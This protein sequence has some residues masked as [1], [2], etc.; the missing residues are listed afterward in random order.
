MQ[1][2]PKLVNEDTAAATAPAELDFERLKAFHQEEKDNLESEVQA[3]RARAREAVARARVGIPLTAADWT[4]WFV[5]NRESF[6]A[7]QRTAPTSRRALCKRWG[8]AADAP[9][10]VPRFAPA[11]DEGV[12][13][14]RNQARWC[15]LLQGRTG[16]YG[17]QMLA[18]SRIKILLVC[19]FR[20]KSYA[21]DM[22]PWQRT[23]GRF[24]ITDCAAVLQ[25]RVRPLGNA[26]EEAD[27]VS[28]VFE[29]CI[30]GA[31]LANDVEL[32]VLSLAQ[33]TDPLPPPKR[34]R[35]S[36]AAAPDGDGASSQEEALAGDASDC[37]SSISEC[38]VD[39]DVDTDVDIEAKRV[40]AKFIAKLK[41]D[42]FVPAPVPAD[43]AAAASAP[44]VLSESEDTEDDAQCGK[45]HAAGTWKTWSNSWF[46]LTHT[47]GEVDIKMHL[48]GTFRK[49]PPYGMGAHPASK[50]LRPHRFG[51]TVDNCWRTQLLV[52]S[53]GAFENVFVWSAHNRGACEF[54]CVQICLG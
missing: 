7:L 18:P 42:E 20:Q 13:A 43:A 50:T 35:A 54:E 37:D 22:E 41:L 4:E 9:D 1:R 38:S 28:H 17:L 12:A 31:A 29:L 33:I 47:A 2:L 25:Q 36:A 32:R 34:Q 45:R 51:E 26:L 14:G 15:Q 39:T 5:R 11:D 49:P 23:C 48:Y 44:A 3:A 27:H 40:G 52:W 10:V 53:E 19:H 46:Y 16:W 30:T 6:V 8:A 24:R 21:V